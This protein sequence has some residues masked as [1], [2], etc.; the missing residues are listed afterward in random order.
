MYFDWF[1]MMTINSGHVSCCTAHSAPRSAMKAWAT[2][3]IR[4]APCSQ[5]GSVSVVTRLPSLKALQQQRL[6][7]RASSNKKKR[8]DQATAWPCVVRVSG[9]AM[10]LR[11]G[12]HCAAVPAT[13][14]SFFNFHKSHLLLLN[15][16]FRNCRGGPLQCTGAA[17]ISRT[18]ANAT[19]ACTCVAKIRAAQASSQHLLTPVVGL[20]VLAKAVG[21]GPSLALP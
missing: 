4:Q 11:E 6:Q 12:C 18:A 7:S 13:I 21:E 3:C 20:F 9:C 19:Q 1:V 14:V 8:Y 17:N 16:T 5:G 15:A 10:L 2:I